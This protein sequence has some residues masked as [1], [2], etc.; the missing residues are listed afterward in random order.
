M[1]V[2]QSIGAILVFIPLAA[3]VKWIPQDKAVMP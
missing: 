2:L 3:A 1:C